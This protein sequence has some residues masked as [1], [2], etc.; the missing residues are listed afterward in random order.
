MRRVVTAFLFAPLIAILAVGI[1]VGNA[2]LATFVTFFFVYP[3]TLILAFP[4]FLLFRR[5]R[6]LQWWHAAAAGTLVTAIIVLNLVEPYGGWNHLGAEDLAQIVLYTSTGYDVAL[7][8]WF[9]G[10]FRNLAYPYVSPRL[11]IAASLIGIVVIPINVYLRIVLE[12][13]AMEGQIIALLPANHGEPQAEVRLDSG[14][15]IQASML[16]YSSYAKGNKVRLDYRRKSFLFKDQ[17]ELTD[18]IPSGKFNPDAYLV[19]ANRCIREAEN[20]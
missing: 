5:L 2:G 1:S 19:D 9:I 15:T 11:P 12:P 6:W 7:I 16:C 17:Y 13:V 4:L 8:F 20:R 14:V 10:I 3:L 18:V